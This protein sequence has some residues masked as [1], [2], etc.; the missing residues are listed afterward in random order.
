MT[1]FRRLT[2]NF[3]LQKAYG[4]FQLNLDQPIAEALWRAQVYGTDMFSS[5]K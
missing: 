1:D 3:P 5:A 2:R 4:I